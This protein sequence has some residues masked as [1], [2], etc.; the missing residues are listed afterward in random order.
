MQSG[1]NCHDKMQITATI[2]ITI[3]RVF[4]YLESNACE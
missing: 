3:E 1:Y 2:K 4:I